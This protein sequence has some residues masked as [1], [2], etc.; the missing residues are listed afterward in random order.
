MKRANKK[1]NNT[2]AKEKYKKQ[3]KTKHN[4]L[5]NNQRHKN[6]RLPLE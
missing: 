4:K 5:I 1:Y 2:K 3:Y 6:N